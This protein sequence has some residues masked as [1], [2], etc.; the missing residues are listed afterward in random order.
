MELELLEP[1]LF[2]AHEPGA[3]ARFADALVRA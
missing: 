1:A 2:F 3:A